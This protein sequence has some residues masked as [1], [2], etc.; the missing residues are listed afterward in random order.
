VTEVTPGR[1]G[2]AGTYQRIILG[3][4]A[5]IAALLVLLAVLLPFRAH[6]S[7]ATP[8][9]VFV[10]PALIGVVIG[11]FVAGAIGA[12][13]GFVFYDVFFL[14]PYDTLTVHSPENWIA[15]VVYVVVVLV[16]AQVVAQ[17][18]EA[19]ENALR[20]T[21]ES[22]RLFELSQTLNGD[23]TL[24]QL[25]SH[26]VAAAQEAFVPAW[27]ALVLPAHTE[28]GQLE[29]AASAGRP[30]IDDD[31]T[32]LTSGGGQARSLGFEVASGPRRV[33]IALVVSERPVGMLV[34]QDVQ[35]GEQDRN[36]LGTFA[37]QAALAVD[38]AQLR[39]QA[40]RARLLEEIDRWRSALMGAASHD[41]RTPLASIKTAVSNMRQEGARLGPADR[42]EL[43]ELVEQQ[44]DRLARLV[45]NLLDMTRIESGALE[46]RPTTLGLDELVEETL[47]SLGG[48][49]APER[50]TVDV[51]ADL[52]L[53]RIDHV[54]ISQVLANVLENANRLATG[55]SPILVA[56]RAAPGS[57]GDR[58]E[59]SVSDDGPGIAPADREAVFDMFSQN[60][61]G[62]RAGLG[63]AIAKAF[64]EAHGGRIWIDPDVTRG[65]RVVFTVPGEA[66]V[67]E[68]A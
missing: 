12:V 1:L 38:R 5:T 53:L 14:P 62:G 45:T 60:G 40:M 24:S 42:A 9:L 50:V 3:T 57:A 59:I 44:T 31:V 66:F 56:A 4:V 49:V 23:F 27:T 6:L 19:R 29:V 13:A 7:I 68:P 2:T 22:V 34:L 15:L 48:I 54:L 35:L 51:P 21:N 11:G 10:L 17:L 25:L 8:A 36:L 47:A 43:L 67:R 18:R 26:I 61:G 63:L 30:L 20:R 28:G 32:S 39:E 55:P 58:V 64:V 41:L 16:L 37:N 46:L 65:A 52:P 33:S